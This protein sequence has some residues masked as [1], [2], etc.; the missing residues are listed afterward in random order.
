MLEENERKKCE[1]KERKRLEWWQKNNYS[2]LNVQL[3][4]DSDESSD[5]DE[6]RGLDIQYL[7]GDVTQP[8][9]TG[10]KDAIIVHCVGM[11]L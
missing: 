3:E 6:E 1:E 11:F 8:Q 2:T 10:T 7:V 9:C 5:D 4:S